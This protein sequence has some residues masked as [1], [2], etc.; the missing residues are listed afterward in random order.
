MFLLVWSQKNISTWI[1]CLNV[2]NAEDFVN[3][4]THKLFVSLY[5]CF[6]WCPLIMLFLPRDTHAWKPIMALNGLDGGDTIVQVSETNITLALRKRCSTAKIW[7]YFT[8]IHFGSR[9][10]REMLYKTCCEKLWRYVFLCGISCEPQSRPR[11]IVKNIP[12]RSC[13]PKNLS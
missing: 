11:P 8:L 10:Y 12:T 6:Q 2:S 9:F 5:A 3:R 1:N 7:P 4:W 13:C